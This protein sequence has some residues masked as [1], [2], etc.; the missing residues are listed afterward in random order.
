MHAFRH[1]PCK[2]NNDQA[3]ICFSDKCRAMSMRDLDDG[4]DWQ[5]VEGSQA[6]LPELESSSC[7]GAMAI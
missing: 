6:A 1:W 7:E 2:L 5:G 3:K 4:N